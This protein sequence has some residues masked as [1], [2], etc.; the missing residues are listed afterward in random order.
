LPAKKKTMLISPDGATTTLP[1]EA[2]KS[3]PQIPNLVG[4][5]NRL[6]LESVAVPAQLL[7]VD[8]D[9]VSPGK[10]KIITRG[11]HL[12]V[13]AL[14]HARNGKEGY[15]KEIVARVHGSVPQHITAALETKADLSRLRPEELEQLRHLLGAPPTTRS[16]T[17][18][19]ENPVV[20]PETLRVDLS[21]GI[22]DALYDTPHNV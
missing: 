19:P 3:P 21:A 12:M 2:S 16:T 20:E 11:E 9:R 14:E 6:L 4:I 8:P 22:S 15:F 1:A 13:C 5:L 7:A 10:K 18:T 17:P